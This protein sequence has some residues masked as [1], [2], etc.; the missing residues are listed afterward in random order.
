VYVIKANKERYHGKELLFFSC[1][2]LLFNV[3]VSPSITKFKLS[4]LWALGPDMKERQ[5]NLLIDTTSSPKGR[6]IFP[7]LF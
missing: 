1:L 6:E 2:L 4:I 5:P 3:N 7:C